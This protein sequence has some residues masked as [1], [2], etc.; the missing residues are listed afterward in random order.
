MPPSLI[1]LLTS[2]LLT[3]KTGVPPQ[4]ANASFLLNEGKKSH[5]A[6]L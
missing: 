1:M 3:V 4:G 6:S 2:K 5:R